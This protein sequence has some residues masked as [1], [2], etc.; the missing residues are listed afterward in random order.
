MLTSRMRL[1]RVLM[2]CMPCS[3]TSTPSMMRYLMGLGGIDS[4][5]GG[6]GSDGTIGGGDI[7]FS[8]SGGGG[9]TG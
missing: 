8:G 4:G 6:G 1:L 3:D 7:G 9:G 5:I 2:C